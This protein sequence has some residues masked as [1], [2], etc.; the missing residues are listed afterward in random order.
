MT[1]FRTIIEKI[2]RK[3]YVKG[4]L[5]GK[6]IGFLDYGLSD[7]AHENYYSIEILEAEI[8]V[9]Q[10]QKWQEGGEFDDFKFV[11]AFPT[12]LPAGTPFLIQSDDGTEIRYALDLKSPK[13]KNIRLSNLVHEENKVF[14][15]IEGDICGYVLRFEQKT[16]QVPIPSNDQSGQSGKENDKAPDFSPIPPRQNAKRESLWK[17]I[18][19][20]LQSLLAI[21]LLVPLIYVGWPFLLL[22]GISILFQLIGQMTQP[23]FRYLG[24]AF[25]SLLWILFLVFVCFSLFAYF[26]GTREMVIYP[27]VV[28]DLPVEKTNTKEIEDQG[29]KDSIISHFRVWEDYSGVKYQGFLQIRFSDWLASGNNRQNAAI[30]GEGIGAYNQLLYQLIKLDS[31]RLSGIY[32][33]FDT[34]RHNKR[35]D[36]KGFAEVIVSCIQDIPYTLILD[37]EC[38]PLLYND[39][40]IYD[41]LT[42]GGVCHPNVKYGIFAPVEFVATLHGDCDTRALLLF[43]ILSHYGYDVAMLN[44]E[45][46]RH[47]VLAVNM[48]YLGISKTINRK[49]Y[50]IWETT[51]AG[52]PPGVFPSQMSNMNLWTLNLVSTNNT[53][54]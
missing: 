31:S 6:Y 27:P 8:R 21:L 38:D 43:T 42:K 3:T 1:E 18:G 29:I 12:K 14:G 45:A 9:A 16:I 52:L 26:S 35:L 48:P 15:T 39:H 28:K 4:Y 40:F 19:A 54:Q 7:L 47:A 41:Y 25:I 24:R 20:I 46:Y 32:T 50:V 23:V 5:R 10:I 49:R 36:E 30:Y 17:S 34:L 13:L 51:Q 33:L 2:E 53:I 37:D 44:S 11:D 22:I